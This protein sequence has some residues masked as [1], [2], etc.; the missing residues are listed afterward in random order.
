MVDGSLMGGLLVGWFVGWMA[1]LSVCLSV[2]SAY[3][4]RYMIDTH[5][6]FLFLFLLFSL[7]YRVMI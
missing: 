7:F 1:G 5:M 6:T 2:G 3:Y 4:Y